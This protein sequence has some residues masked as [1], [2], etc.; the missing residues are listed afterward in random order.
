[1]VGHIDLDYFYAQVEEVENP[2][3]RRVPTVVCVFSG[4]TKESGVVS[5][6]NYRARELGVKSGMPIVFAKR[7]L[8]SFAPVFVSM[9]HEKY[10]TISNKVMELVRARVDALEQAGIDEAFFDITDSSGGNYSRAK[11]IAKDIKEIIRSEHHLTS[12]VGLGPNKIVARIASNFKKPDGLTVVTPQ[13]VGSFLRPLGVDSLYGVGAKTSKVLLSNGIGTI[14]ELADANPDVLQ[15]LFGKNFG[16][17]LHEAANGTSDELVAERGQATQIS[18]IITLGRDTLI[19]SEI[20]EQLRP[21]IKAVNDRVE[22]KRLSFKNVSIIAVLSDLSVR[23]KSKSLESPTSDLNVLEENSRLLLEELVRALD[24]GI[25]RAG[26]RVSAFHD[27]DEQSS[28][29]EYV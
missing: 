3:L 2:S 28:L 4:R 8:A 1:V 9:K 10:E 15:K 22:S 26:V 7:K 27:S 24:K 12:S 6:A 20:L 11:D 18:R 21:M 25:R 16:I 29:S 5:T 23:T 14:G 13:E 19:P 17:Y